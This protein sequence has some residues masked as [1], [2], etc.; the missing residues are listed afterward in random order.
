M[1]SDRDNKPVEQPADPAVDE[2]GK[3]RRQALLRL[4]K[5]TAPAMLALL[6]S[7]EAAWAS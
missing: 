1:T 5:Y 4:A 2:V 6:M 3:S 7:E